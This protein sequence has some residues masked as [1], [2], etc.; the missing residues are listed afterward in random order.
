MAAMASACKPTRQRIRIWTAV[1]R[2]AAQHVDE[3]EAERD[4][5]Q[6]HGGADE[7]AGESGIARS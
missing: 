6:Q 4:E 1:R 5:H 7:R 3:A 2:A